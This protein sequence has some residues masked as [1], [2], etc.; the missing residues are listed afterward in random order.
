[1]PHIR[2]IGSAYC[3]YCEVG[4]K[5]SDHDRKTNERIKR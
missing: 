5:E 3:G 2:F 4:E 1:M